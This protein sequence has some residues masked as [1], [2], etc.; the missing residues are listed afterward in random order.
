[1]YPKTITYHG[2]TFNGR[3]LSTFCMKNGIKKLSLFGSVLSNDFG[4]QSD[5]DVLIEFMPGEIVGFFRLIR[6]ERELSSFFKGRKVDLRT[7]GDI[8]KYFRDRVLTE[9]EVLYVRRL[10]TKNKTYA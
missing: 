4:P 10:S 6:I 5:I 9:A 2:I 1:M 7:V 8:S 3:A